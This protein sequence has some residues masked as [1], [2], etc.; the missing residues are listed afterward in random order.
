MNK[1]IKLTYSSNLSDRLVENSIKEYSKLDSFASNFVN[2][3][4]P[5]C[6]KTEIEPP[7][8]VDSRCLS[9]LDTLLNRRHSADTAASSLSINT[10]LFHYKDERKSVSSDSNTDLT[11]IVLN[12]RR[13]GRFPSLATTHNVDKIKCL[14]CVE[15]NNCLN[16]DDLITRRHSFNPSDLNRKIYL[17]QLANKTVERFSNFSKN[18]IKIS[19]PTK[20]S[21]TKSKTIG[22][23]NSDSNLNNLNDSSSKMVSSFKQYNKVVIKSIL[24]KNSS[25][26]KPTKKE[27]NSCTSCRA[28]SMNS[29]LNIVSNKLNSISNSLFLKDLVDDI[30]KKAFTEV[31]TVTK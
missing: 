24:R 8:Y 20:L 6:I 31:K 10:R 13:S 2:D 12:N 7:D 28:S 25:I 16:T 26:V 27:Q 11:H 1:D 5:D 9:S 29:E 14:C 21:K 18:N 30:F 3:L 23:A 4:F 15:S 19:F 22:F 17:S